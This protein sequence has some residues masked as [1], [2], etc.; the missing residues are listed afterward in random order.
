[1]IIKRKAVI[2][3]QKFTL[4]VEEN[5]CDLTPGEGEILIQTHCSLI[6]AGTELSYYAGTNQQLIGGDKGFPYTPGHCN[7]GTVLAVGPGETRIQ[8]GAH[9]LSFA[10]HVSHAVVRSA[11]A[12]VFPQDAD[13]R[14]ALF[15][16]MAGIALTG[17]LA[18]GKTRNSTVAVLG[19]GMLGNLAVQLAHADGNRVVGI[20][21]SAFRAEMLRQIGL[22]AV[23]A[24]REQDMQAGVL[25]VLGEAPEIVIDATG[26]A[27]H[28]VP[29]LRLVRSR[30][31]FVL[32]GSPRET[33]L[34]DVYNLIHVPGIRM[35][36]A[37][38]K[39]RA[40]FAVGTGL[41]TTGRIMEAMWQQIASGQVQA[42]R[43]ITHEFPVDEAEKAYELLANDHDHVLGVML[44][45]V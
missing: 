41:E 21:H 37:H 8:I 34:L 15:M 25:A 5:D 29:G 11:E 45:W 1:M 14:D 22:P 44:R 42:S 40:A 43:L 26:R 38:M 12:F 9:V 19:L 16:Q 39:N 18:A 4:R 23:T 36:G 24:I 17:L 35:V 7:V 13:W 32:F 33:I 27:D 10:K 30:G 28:I 2:M 20:S 3:S 31:T 6:S